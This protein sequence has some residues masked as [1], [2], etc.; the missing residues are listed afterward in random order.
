MSA[1]GRCPS[2]SSR[3]PAAEANVSFSHRKRT[4]GPAAALRVA[5]DPVGWLAA[6]AAVVTPSFKTLVAAARN[7]PGRKEERAGENRS[8]GRRHDLICCRHE[9]V[10][11]TNGRPRGRDE[12]SER[13]Q[14]QS[15]RRESRDPCSS[16]LFRIDPPEFFIHPNNDEQDRDQKQNLKKRQRIGLA[17]GDPTSEEGDD[18]EQGDVHTSSLTPTRRVRKGSVHVIRVLKAVR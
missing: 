17:G 8:S 1:L 2:F 18:E 9:L 11:S 10:E 14:S 7:Q 13:D 4:Y 3:R 6:P 15:S 5:N 12:A 16:A